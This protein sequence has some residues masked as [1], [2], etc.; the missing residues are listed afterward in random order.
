V[1]KKLGGI[2]LMLFIA[3]IQLPSQQVKASVVT[4]ELKVSS[5]ITEWV[6]DNPTNTLYAIS[7]TD[8]KLMF[9]NSDTM[10]IEKTLI[11]GGNPTDVIKDN[12]KL[13]IALNSVHQIVIVDMASRTIT[14][15][16]YTKS[17]PYRLAK[18]GNKIYYAEGRQWCN[19]Y[20]HDLITN[21]S[22]I[23]ESLSVYEAD[24]EMNLDNHI[25]YI[26][27]SRSGG[28]NMVYYSTLDNKVIG[29]TNYGDAYDSSYSGRRVVFDGTKVYYAGRDF[30]PD[31]PKK[32]DGDFGNTERVIYAKNGLVYTSKSIYEKDSHMKLGYYGYNADLV[33]ASDNTLYIYNKAANTIKMFSSL[34]EVVDS[35]NIISLISGTPATV[36]PNTAQSTKINSAISSLEM[37]SKL[38]QWLLHKPTN[39][40]YGISDEDKALFFVNAETLNIEKSILFKS[41]PT[42]IIEDGGKLYIALDDVH[43]IVIID[44]ES[45]EITKTLYTTSDPYRIVKEG[46]K[47]YYAERD[48]SCYIYEYNLMLGLDQK[49]NMTAVGK[50]DLAIN[51]DDHI[52]YIGESDYSGSDMIY[53]STTDNK[54]IG[55]TNYKGGYGFPYPGRYTIFDGEKV[56]FAGYAFDK[57]D[58]TRIL[59][60]Y[61]DGDVVFAKY[62]RVF[63]DTAMYDSETFELLSHHDG[64]I[65]LYETSEKPVMYYYSQWSKAILKIDPSKIL[66][67]KFNSQGGSIVED[68]T[69][70]EGDPIDTPAAPTKT[71]YTFGGWYK[72]AECRNAWNFKTDTA[73]PN[74]T[75]YAK[76]IANPTAPSSVKA[77]PSS[78][79]SINVSWGAVSGAS[80]YEVY[81]AA[82]ETGAYTLIKTTTALSYNNSEL[83]TSSTYYYRIKAYN[84]VGTVKAYSSYSTMVS[85]KPI[86][87]TPTSPKAAASSY[88]SIN[89]SWGA[90][91]GAS[92][93]EVY[94]AASITGA[95][96]LIKT[97]TALSYNNSEL[98]T[99]STYYYKIRAYRTVGT[100]KAY[101][102]YSTMVSAKPILSTPTSPKAAAS[103]YNSINVSW[104]AVSGA[105][106]YEVY[107]AASNTGAYTLIK[108]TTALSYNNSELATNSTYYYKIRAYRTVGTVK[109][110][111]SYSTMV[112]AKPILSTPT[113]PKAASSSY[114]SIKISWAAVAGAVG[115]EIYRAASSTG[116][117]SL[118]ASTTATSYNN[119]AL[120]TGKTYYYKVRAYR[121][122]GSTKVYSSFTAVFSSKPILSVPVNFKATR[123]SSTSIKVTWSAV[124]GASG[125][126]IYRATS[127]TGQY[128]LIKT[129]SSLYYTNTGLTTGKTYYYKIR[130]YRTVGTTKVY[131][132]WTTVTYAR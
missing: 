87:S 54:V 120:T 128:S 46:N 21:M 66:A 58:P 71:G 83:A 103:S 32:F 5:A 85:A 79:N 131:S 67:V 91:S 112:S 100:V 113:S 68:I 45:R 125:Y 55:K 4:G 62:G 96:T 37:K 110:Y 65:D 121:L 6:L 22:R 73:T 119:T 98:A 14:K 33:E 23:L 94:R 48:Q 86:L 41:K 107:R 84:T 3:L 104:G 74:L 89:V 129:T 39:T 34:D 82:S 105:S 123:Y 57:Q 90:V 117:Y 126:E 28:S 19:I 81:R 8:K 63:T 72:E 18:E 109:A 24:L 30:K 17:E 40:L 27:E 95:Y 50:P 80:G 122:V 13:Y 115:Y 31:D 38:I 52:L 97:T 26:G 61:D 106:G 49:I 51:P 2:L 114:N 88:N 59:G 11:L 35:S 10:S 36:I 93:Y 78:Y 77:V 102:S 111:G 124:S 76:W 132:N 25:L 12:G 42:D 60:N 53:Y 101:S 9:I 1:F 69:A 16:I 43:Q 70:Y 130:A 44:M 99:N 75:L 108:T 15:T 20:E 56:Y 64:D 127:S 92:G 116:T 47:I 7:E 118:L 29:K